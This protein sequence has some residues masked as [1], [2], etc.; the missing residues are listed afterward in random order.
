MIS[1][2]LSNKVQLASLKSDYVERLG[3]YKRSHSKQ[4]LT[5]LNTIIDDYVS[6][7]E[8]NDVREKVD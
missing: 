2:S 3:F 1:P 7:I 8:V 4:A 6:F 5:R